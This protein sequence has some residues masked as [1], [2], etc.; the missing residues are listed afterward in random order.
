MIHLLN[1]AVM[2]QAGFYELQRISLATFTEEV[3]EAAA[4][5]NFKHYIGYQNTLELIESLTG[6]DLGKI[7]VD[8][9][10]LADGDI[11]YV[12]RLRRRVSP[13]SK[14]VATRSDADALEISDFDF[15]RGKY[16]D[17]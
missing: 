14:R 3:S 16:A 11:F 12:A 9:T 6:V 7:N 4:D 17:A 8:Q 13:A 15:F 5:E 1:A 2:P 10:E